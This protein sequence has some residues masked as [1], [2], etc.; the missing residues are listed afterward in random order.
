M[1]RITV[2]V[3]SAPVLIGLVFALLSALFTGSFISLAAPT[4]NVMADPSTVITGCVGS[5]N[6][7]SSTLNLGGRTI[8]A[9]T[10]VR[11]D[12]SGTCAADEDTL[13]WSAGAAASTF[14][15][16]I[17]VTATDDNIDN[18][19]RLLSAMTTISNAVPTAQHPYMLEL[20]PGSYDLDGNSLNLVQFMTLKGA[21]EN[22]TNIISSFA[23]SSSL[24]AGILNLTSDD[25]VKDLSV[26]S[27]SDGT[28]DYVACIYA[29]YTAGTDNDLSATV[30]DH[31]TV[32]TIF[33]GAV[34]TYGLYAGSTANLKI[35]DSSI[36]TTVDGPLNSVVLGIDSRGTLKIQN[37]QVTGY[38]ANG[39]SGDNEVY[40]VRINAGTVTIEQSTL[41]AFDGKEANRALQTGGTSNV[42]VKNSTLNANSLQ[43]N[44]NNALYTNSS[45]V[46]IV[47]NGILTTSST[48]GGATNQ[49]IRNLGNIKI[50]ASQLGGTI[51]NFGTIKCANSYD[52]NFDELG[53]DCTNS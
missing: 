34:G 30:L 19:S 48:D 39:A 29:N 14:N 23:S 24:T 22:K 3:P 44:L 6:P 2:P 31:V 28:A 35:Q 21:G 27:T 5:T 15:H 18:G 37:S 16:T 43:A 52:A 7:G 45:E 46:V 41:T 11:I 53:S 1:K 47:E 40:G 4:A 38:S 26:I 36:V 32:T 51:L 13:T 50:G 12:P 25:L 20:E 49:V 33:G 8:T 42:S 17:V 9:S 10:L